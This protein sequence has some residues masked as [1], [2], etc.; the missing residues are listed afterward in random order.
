MPGRDWVLT[1]EQ[2]LELPLDVIGLEILRDILSNPMN[3]S[4]TW[5][6]MA[7][8]AYSVEGLRALGEA[9][10]WLYVNGLVATDRLSNAS[11]AVFVTRSGRE[12]VQTG[13]TER[14]RASAR[15]DLDLH[16][17]LQGHVRPQFLM[18]EYEIAAFAAMKAVEVRVRKLCGYSDSE[19]GVKLMMHAFG[20]GAPLCEAGLDG[21]ELKARQDLFAGAIGTIKNPTSHRDV[22]YEDPT[23]ASEVVL[24]ADLLMRILD[25]IP[26][27]APSS[28]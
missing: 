17:S 13:D 1:E 5:L 12:V 26:S 23:E 11:A 18:G 25:R 24:L 20:P 10:E 14:L 3:D 22:Y 7:E 28:S 6:M 9:W 2:I 4:R 8:P 21:G 27:P 15:L 19:I 16:P